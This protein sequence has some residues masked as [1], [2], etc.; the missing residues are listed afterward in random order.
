MKQ[1][2]WLKEA[3]KPHKNSNAKPAESQRRYL[4]LE[5]ALCKRPCLIIDG[6]RYLHYGSEEQDCRVEKWVKGSIQAVCEHCGTEI[7]TW[8]LFYWRLFGL[9]S[10]CHEKAEKTHV[11]DFVQTKI[12][13]GKPA[14][15]WEKAGG[16]EKVGG[17]VK[18]FNGQHT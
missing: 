7:R 5:R 4:S 15:R 13:D 1:R 14:F 2:S 8:N 18:I 12:V 6:T 17:S 10:A 11:T 16:K 3:Y 9:C